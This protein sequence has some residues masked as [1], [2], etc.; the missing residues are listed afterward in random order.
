MNC[1]TINSTFD[2]TMPVFKCYKFVF[3]TSQALSAAGGI[4]TM[5]GVA[6]LCIATA[7]LLIFNGKQGC[8]SVPQCLCTLWVQSCIFGSASILLIVLPFFDAVN[9]AL[10]DKNTFAENF[11]C[12]SDS[13]FAV[14]VPWCHFEKELKEQDNENVAVNL[15]R[16]SYPVKL[17]GGPPDDGNERPLDL[18]A[19]EAQDDYHLMKN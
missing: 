19:N 12:F 9:D 18:T 1:S 4:L 16:Q 10:E 13:F 6:F 15:P 5:R 2:G 7:I 3:E 8:N 14:G 11:G 17:L